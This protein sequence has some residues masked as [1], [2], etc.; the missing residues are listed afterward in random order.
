M[1]HGDDDASTSHP[2]LSGSTFILPGKSFRPFAFERSLTRPD[3]IH[4]FIGCSQSSPSCPGA[5]DVSVWDLVR[6]MSQLGAA[7]LSPLSS[8]F[9]DSVRRRAGSSG[10]FGGSGELLD[11]FAGRSRH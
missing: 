2:R 7:L 1:L 6:S 4:S 9:G 8:T 10:G 5:P 11:L 3:V